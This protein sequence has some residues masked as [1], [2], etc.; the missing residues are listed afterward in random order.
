MSRGA[1]RDLTKVGVALCLLEQA[2]MLPVRFTAAVEGSEA[3]PELQDP[4]PRGNR[5][6]S[7][8]RA[9]AGGGMFH[10]KHPT[11]RILLVAAAGGA[12]AYAGHRLHRWA[13][14]RW[15]T[16]RSRPGA[17]SRWT[18]S[19]P[20]WA[21]SSGWRSPS[22]RTKRRSRSRTIGRR[23]LVQVPIPQLARVAPFGTAAAPA[24]KPPSI[25][26][27]RRIAEPIQKLFD[28]WE[29]EGLTPTAAR[30]SA[31]LL[32][33]DR[34]VAPRK[35]RGTET[36]LS[37][38]AFGA[39]FDVN[40]QYNPQGVAARPIG[41]PGSVLALVPHREAPGLVLGRLVR[42][43]RSDA[44]RVRRRSPEHEMNTHPAL[45]AIL[46]P[47]GAARA[48]VGAYDEI[49]DHEHLELARWTRSCGGRW[50]SGRRP[51]TTRRRRGRRPATSPPRPTARPWAWISWATWASAKRT[52]R[53]PP[54]SGRRRRRSRSRRPRR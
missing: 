23:N 43:P 16:A 53:S 50:G 12:L 37:T 49:G 25:G 44:L 9:L 42:K 14:F 29:K 10:V 6:E 45:I 52:R 54:S 19:R 41:D 8:V 17:R 36:L 39:A 33:W 3:P 35:R 34:L 5:R 2:G 4:A 30:P 48:A 21:R 11:A 22:P 13:S 18:S 1:S 38:H 20:R 51:S 32:T 26:V 40:A 24:A 46:G 27:H 7:G 15:A 47:Q 31:V 28:A